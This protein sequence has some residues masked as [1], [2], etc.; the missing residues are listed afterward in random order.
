MVCS[1]CAYNRY[2]VPGIKF[3]KFPAEKQRRDKWVSAI[4]RHK[5]KPNE[6]SRVCSSHFI[7]GSPCRILSVLIMFLLYSLLL[8]KSLLINTSGQNV[9]K[10]TLLKEVNLLS[11]ENNPSHYLQ[12]LLLRTQMMYRMS[13][14]VKA[15]MMK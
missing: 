3:F 12:V 14:R 11:E 10:F 9:E 1:C 8:A 2:G 4:R 6:Y 15:V 5:W 7:S 13:L